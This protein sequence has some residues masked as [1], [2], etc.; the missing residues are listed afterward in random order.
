MG[1]LIDT[2]LIKKLTVVIPEADVQVMDSTPYTLL[3]GNGI[4]VFVPIACTIQI[5][6][7]QTTPYTGF[8]HLH[9]MNTQN[10]GVGN[11]TATYSLN[12]SASNNLT[13]GNIL[14]SMLCNFQ[15]SPNRFG[16]INANK[17]IEIFFDAAVTGDGDMIVNLFYYII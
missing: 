15:A 11:I 6:A 13:T 7:N 14:Y 1:Y 12:A 16:G 9:L 8:T 10:P 4:N 2:G 17:P 5:A 3:Q